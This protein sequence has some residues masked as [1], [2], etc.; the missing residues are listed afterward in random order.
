MNN[1]ALIIFISQENLFAETRV[2]VNQ[3]CGR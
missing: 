3:I 2:I 1:V